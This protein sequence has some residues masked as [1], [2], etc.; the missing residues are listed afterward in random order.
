MKGTR[1][2]AS[3]LVQPAKSYQGLVVEIVACLGLLALGLSIR[4]V[5]TSV[6]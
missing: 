5:G 1:K 6:L 3:T 4:I 2:S